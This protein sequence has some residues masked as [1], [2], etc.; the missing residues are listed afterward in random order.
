MLSTVSLERNT[1]T[2]SFPPSLPLSLPPSLPPSL[3]GSLQLLSDGLSFQALHVE[4]VSSGGEDEER[5]DRDI[6]PATLEQVVQSRQ[7]LK[8][9]ISSLVRELVPNNKKTVKYIH[10]WKMNI[11]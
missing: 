1:H 11:L 4:A 9:Q 2:L 8:K 10:T 5:H 7:R 6:A 3:P